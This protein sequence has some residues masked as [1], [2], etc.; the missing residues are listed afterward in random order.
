MKK[1]FEKLAEVLTVKSGPASQHN[2]DN[3]INL[4]NMSKN[5]TVKLLVEVLSSDYDKMVSKGAK[6]KLFVTSPEG[7]AGC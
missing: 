3:G 4:Q 1:I 2:L 7:M 6:G 5:D